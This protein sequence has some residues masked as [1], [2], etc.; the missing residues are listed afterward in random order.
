MGTGWIHR[1]LHFDN[2]QVGLDGP[3]WMFPTSCM[4]STFS[5]LISRK[6]GRR[7]SKE[8]VQ[9][10]SIRYK[11]CWFLGSLDNEISALILL[12]MVH[13]SMTC[14]LS[15]EL[16][17]LLEVKKAPWWSCWL[18]G[19][20]LPSVCPEPTMLHCFSG[21]HSLDCSLFQDRMWTWVAFGISIPTSW[22]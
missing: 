11:H 13:C 19:Y 6:A 10:T 12:L 4:Q 16:T 1:K 18:Y 3:F 22:I 5:R 15:C 2:V 8:G 20:F 9:N 7:F 14:T 21:Y 17:H